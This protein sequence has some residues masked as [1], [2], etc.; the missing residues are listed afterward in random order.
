MACVLVFAS[1]IAL[2][3]GDFLWRGGNTNFGN[4]DNWSEKF[5]PGANSTIPCGTTFGSNSI[6]IISQLSSAEY[7]VGQVLN[8]PANGALRL[9]GDGTILTFTD[10][11]SST[12]N[13][14]S[15]V[16][17]G[18]LQPESRNDFN[19][20]SNWVDADSGVVSS[21]PPCGDVVIFDDLSAYSVSLSNTVTL[22]NVREIRLG[23]TV[24]TS[25]T[26]QQLNQLLPQVNVTDTTAVVYVG[27]RPLSEVCRPLGLVTSDN[28]CSCFSSCPT[29]AM[30]LQQQDLQRIQAQNASQQLFLALGTYYT[31]PFSGTM[32]PSSLYLTSSQLTNLFSDNANRAA[33]NNV[34]T[35]NLLA[36]PASSVSGLQ[37]SFDGTNVLISGSINATLGNLLPPGS[38]STTA[39][40]AIN[41]VS[42][43]PVIPVNAPR[44]QTI[45]QT[46]SASTLLGQY[47]SS[48]NS[49]VTTTVSQQTSTTQTVLNQLVPIPNS[50]TIF[51]T[52]NANSCFSTC[53]PS[54]TLCSTCQTSLVN[55]LTAIGVD[56]TTA[57]SIATNLIAAKDANA[58]T[59]VQTA[60]NITDTLAKA[61]QAAMVQQQ[62]QQQTPVMYLVPSPHFYAGRSGTIGDQLIATNSLNRGN[63]ITTITNV[64]ANFQN[65]RN[66]LNVNASF[67]GSV[68]S[69]ARR[70]RRALETPSAILVDLV[71]NISCLPT[72]TVCQSTLSTA[73]S[74]YSGVLSRINAAVSGLS[75]SVRCKNSITSTTFS[76]S[77]IDAIGF[78]RCQ[79]AVA[80]GSNISYARSLASD[81]MYDVT[82]CGT[83]SPVPYPN[84]TCIDGSQATDARDNANSL[85]RNYL[86]CSSSATVPP[87]I[88]TAIPVTTQAPQAPITDASSG[89]GGGG[90]GM[91]AGA[92]GGGIAIILII[93]IVVVMRRKKQPQ[94]AKTSDDRT[95][96]AFENP[97]YDDPATTGAGSQPTYDSS[98]PAEGGEGLYDEPA[99]NSSAK[100]NPVYQSTEDLA[101]GGEYVDGDG[102][103]KGDGYLDVSP[104]TKPDDV[105]YLG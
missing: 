70:R 102:V 21:T 45:V 38:T 105:G 16:W 92:A 9:A 13:G 2:C 86:D 42:T 97:M 75:L 31:R 35:A 44:I 103:Q 104:N 24:A 14:P 32:S 58:A 55:A 93:L 59:W 76:T 64:L 4:P 63:L 90:L 71:F 77:C 60:S 19:C 3:A 46:S 33:L 83:V 50:T 67:V 73:S 12:C 47:A 89:G 96:V 11:G 15:A 53:S 95:V 72:D 88:T 80:D 41:W 74:L 99:F 20:H 94:K 36:L 78:A 8:L 100:A 28:K 10:F 65:I 26:T 49:Q 37:V 23:T 25:N 6:N 61:A 40:S 7:S 87:V 27:T 34:I 54:G 29:A 82:K 1:I 66:V 52:A 84:G 39:P 85:A 30:L 69:Q 101:A 51:T 81:A 79:S 68:P 57:T 48:L 56:S 18:G 62:Q 43:G 91:A 98:M 22:V 17:T 5:V